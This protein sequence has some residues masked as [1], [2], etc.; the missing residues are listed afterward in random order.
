M[1]TRVFDD[2]QVA[3]IFRDVM[4]AVHFLHVRKVFHR[5]IKPEN[6]LLDG[7]GNFKLCDFGFS[8]IFGN[9]ENRKT[10]CGTKEYLAPEVICSDA[11]DDKVDIWCMGVLLFELVHKRPPYACKN[12]M[13]LYNEIKM[14]KLQFKSGINPDFRRIIEMC[15]QFEPTARPTAELIVESFGWL[16]DRSPTTKVGSDNG[17]GFGGARSRVRVQEKSAPKVNIN[18]GSVNINIVN[19]ASQEQT[20]NQSQNQARSM[21]HI[22]VQTRPVP[23]ATSPYV[24]VYTGLPHAES[25]RVLQ[26]PVE[27]RDSRTQKYSLTG[28]QETK[29]TRTVNQNQHFNRPSSELFDPTLNYKFSDQTVFH[30][31]STN[32]TNTPS[33]SNQPPMRPNQS[34]EEIR[35]ANSLMDNMRSKELYQN[36][37]SGNTPQI[38]KE[39]RQQPARVVIQ[40]Q[41]NVIVR[42]SPIKSSQPQSFGHIETSINRN[43]G[44]SS[45]HSFSPAP[46]PAT[47]HFSFVTGQ[48]S[49]TRLVNQLQPSSWTNHFDAIQLERTPVT[50]YEDP[51]LSK[52]VPPPSTSN[53]HSPNDFHRAETSRN[54]HN[55]S[56][57]TKVNGTSAHHM[58]VVNI[59][60]REINEGHG[61][62]PNIYKNVVNN[63]YEQRQKERYFPQTHQRIPTAPPYQVPLTPMPQKT[64]SNPV[65][66]IKPQ[67]MSITRMQTETH[68]PQQIQN[69]GNSTDRR[70]QNSSSVPRRINSIQQHQLPVTYTH[71]IIHQPMV[72]HKVIHQTPQVQRT[73]DVRSTSAQIGE[74]RSVRYVNYY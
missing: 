43:I 1:R 38:N 9:G 37:R 4:S 74:V 56:G 50:K 21:Q 28:K 16:I 30:H 24:N 67:T 40:S 14:R 8:A 26:V 10:L 73:R 72:V 45:Q 2:Y 11:Q 71:E 6:V 69:A 33:P 39:E 63:D 42:Q 54:L 3:K 29:E 27:N 32:L 53:L 34:D 60:R 55:A 65:R 20:Q 36:H 7:Q 22:P 51:S 35:R 62:Q 61:Q 12:I 59:Y 31:A 5:D 52:T 23:Q 15:L 41:K 44:P 64:A 66:Y 17:S 46:R 68:F 19:Q 58:P 70:L 57:F 25:E 18:I 48:E 13:T 47:K 49:N